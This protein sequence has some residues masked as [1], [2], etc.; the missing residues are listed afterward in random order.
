MTQTIKKDKIDQSRWTGDE[1]DTFD[2]LDEFIDND[3]FCLRYLSL[4]ERTRLH[5]TVQTLRCVM[6]MTADKNL[7][8]ISF[9][10]SH[11]PCDLPSGRATSRMYDNWELTISYR[12]SVGNGETHEYCININN[13]FDCN[14]VDLEKDE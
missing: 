6:N 4:E 2:E 12:K 9:F 3:A 1:F 10:G 14:L 7:L 5:K 8:Y 13:D 11:A